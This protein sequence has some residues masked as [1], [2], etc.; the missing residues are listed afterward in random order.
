[1]DV[2][3]YKG[4]FNFQER[5]WNKTSMDKLKEL[6]QVALMAFKSQHNMTKMPGKETGE[7]AFKE[8]TAKRLIVSRSTRQSRVRT[9]NR[10]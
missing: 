5:D 2:L 1:M 7:D 9:E 8:W 10:E 6:R 3:E 4:T